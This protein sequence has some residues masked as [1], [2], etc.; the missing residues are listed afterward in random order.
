MS[1]GL[2]VESE[3][4]NLFRYALHLCGRDRDEAED[5]VQD[6]MLLALRAEHQFKAGTN[7]SGWLATIMR[8]KRFDR[9]RMRRANRIVGD[10]EGLHTAHMP[11]NDDPAAALEARDALARL[12][13]LP[14][15][16]SR[17]MVMMG[18]GMSLHDV[19]AK[20][21]VPEGTIKSRVHRGRTMLAELLGR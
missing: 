11:G 7:L 8:N 10:P 21:G 3:R 13:D 9:T 18:E 19:A 15:T 12:A 20:E 1:F 14:T 4:R 5:L 16:H 17:A 6:T 2:A